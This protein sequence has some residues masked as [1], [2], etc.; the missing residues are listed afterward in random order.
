MDQDEAAWCF[1]GDLVES[2]FH[3][4]LACEVVLVRGGLIFSRLFV[5]LLIGSLRGFLLFF[6]IV[7][8]FFVVVDLVRHLLC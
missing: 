7:V 3:L 5:D 2:A 8:V 6:D 4:F 1:Y